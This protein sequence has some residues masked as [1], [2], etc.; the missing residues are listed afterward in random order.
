MWSSYVFFDGIDK[1]SSVSNLNKTIKKLFTFPISP[2]PCLGVSFTPFS[3]PLINFTTLLYSNCLLGM[4]VYNGFMTRLYQTSILKV[5]TGNC[6]RTAATN[7]SITTSLQEHTFY[8]IIFNV[9]NYLWRCH[10]ECH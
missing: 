4:F 6:I 5:R 8:L 10:H 2:P 9:V 1:N 3:D 7:N